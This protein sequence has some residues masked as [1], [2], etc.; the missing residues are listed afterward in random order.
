MTPPLTPRQA[1]AN[2][3]RGAMAERRVTQQVLAEKAAISQSSLTRKLGG[4][5]AITVDELER[6]ATALGLTQSSLIAKAEALLAEAV[7]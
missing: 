1:V 5:R 6:I 2:A 4:E 7:A 3:V